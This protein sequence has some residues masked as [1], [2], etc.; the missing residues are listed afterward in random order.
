MH[1]SSQSLL[2]VLSTL[3][4]LSNVSAA[5]GEGKKGG[6]RKQVADVEGRRAQS[7]ATLDP[8]QGFITDFVDSTP[9]PVGK[10][11]HRS[12]R[13]LFNVDENV[14]DLD[15]GDTPDGDNSSADV[16][17]YI[18]GGDTAAHPHPWFGLGLD[19]NN[20]SYSRGPCGATMISPRWAV[21]AA[22]CISNN[23]K[24]DMVRRMDY[25]YVGA[26]KPWT[27]SPIDSTL[28]N[29]GHPYQVIKIKSHIEHPAH[30]ARAGSAHDIALLELEEDVS[31]Y[32]PGFCPMDL[33]A[34]GDEANLANNYPGYAYGFGDTSYGGL[35]SKT[36][37][38][39]QLGYVN[40]NMCSRAMSQW[41]VSDDIV[42]FGGNGRDDACSG[43]SGGPIIVNDKIVGAV[44][45]GYRCASN[46]YPGVFASVEDHLD[47][48][49]SYTGKVPLKNPSC[50]PGGMPQ[51]QRAE[52]EDDSQPEEPVAQSSYSHYHLP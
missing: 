36:L 9:V 27:P 31:P 12:G 13:M 5:D 2:L 34:R 45:W 41:G 52:P 7:A 10:D 37:K 11:P 20:G 28:G 22:H 17:G 26:W 23:S 25:L 32:F 48:I 50:Y 38:E 49:Y 3:C 24:N 15:A 47:W 39:V 1:V 16:Q 51:Q 33:P 6:L 18:V 8:F 40:H 21:T 4:A 44:S 42:C 29:A 30:V 14:L 35:N 43:D 19:F 46:G